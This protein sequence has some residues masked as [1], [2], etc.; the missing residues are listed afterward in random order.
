MKA[1]NTKILPSAHYLIFPSDIE[2]FRPERPKI[3]LLKDIQ[4]RGNFGM[5]AAYKGNNTSAIAYK[6]VSPEEPETKQSEG[7]WVFAIFVD[8]KFVK[9]V[10]TPKPEAK[11]IEKVADKG[12]PSRCPGSA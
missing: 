11:D 4:W 9:L 12:T 10:R 6:L 7:E 5:A 2:K 3:D 8:D 1:L